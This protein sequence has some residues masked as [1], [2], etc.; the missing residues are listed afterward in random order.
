[1]TYFF[2]YQCYNANL[3]ANLIGQDFET[4]INGWSSFD[5]FKHEIFYARDCN[6][7]AN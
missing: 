3:R 2:L 6:N 5:P 7:I 1:M 4:P